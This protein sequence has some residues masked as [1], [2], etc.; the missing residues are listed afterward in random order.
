[1]SA[2]SVLSAL[3]PPLQ[4]LLPWWW[5]LSDA[6]PLSMRALVAALAL[7]LAL[8]IDHRWGEPPAWRHPVV[9]MG[10]ALGWLGLRI[11]PGSHAPQDGHPHALPLK[12]TSI[13]PVVPGAVA[14]R[15]AARFALGALGWWALAIACLLLAGLLWLLLWLPLQALLLAGVQVAG[16]SGEVVSCAAPGCAALWAQAVLAALL[17]GLCLKPLLAWRMLREE[18]WAVETALTRGLD[19]GRRQ[20]ARL[21]SRDTAALDEQLV[22]ESAIETLAE[23]LN[24]SVISPLLWFVLGGL[25]AALLYRFAN[26]ADAMWGYPGWRGRG[27]QRRHW[28]WAGKWAARADDVLGWPGARL[29]AILLWCATRGEVQ[30]LVR[31]DVRWAGICADAALT[32]SPNGGWPMGAVARALGVRLGKPGCYVL[33]ADAAPPRHG[34]IAVAI[35]LC[36]RALQLAALLCLLVLL[37]AVL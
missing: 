19:D 16:L 35:V 20:L 29:C 6:S 4:W 8:W 32:P 22:R 12:G 33:N 30:G 27:A 10:W 5:P 13:L 21:V 9:W 37:A 28:Q 14:G 7:L 3:L 1:M 23:N 15:A 11:A 18:V 24:D 26:T 25:G 17:L 36:R 31:Q 34:H 2:A